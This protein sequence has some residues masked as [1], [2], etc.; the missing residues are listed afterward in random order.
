MF[1]EVVKADYSFQ[2]AI[3][4]TRFFSIKKNE[5]TGK[6]LCDYSHFDTFQDAADYCNKINYESYLMKI[7]EVEQ[8]KSKWEV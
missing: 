1:E 4:A 2:I 7:K 6:F 5:R 3:G 8:M